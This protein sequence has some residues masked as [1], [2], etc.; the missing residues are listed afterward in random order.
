MGK[1]DKDIYKYMMVSP[2]R[3]TN[4]TNRV[5]LQQF[6]NHIQ[7]EITLHLHIIMTSSFIK[8]TITTVIN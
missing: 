7:F 8:R 2:K 1:N 5:L 4:K 3:C 6:T